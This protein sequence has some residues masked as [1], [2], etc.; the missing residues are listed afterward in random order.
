MN[1]FKHR[2]LNVVRALRESPHPACFTMKAWAHDCGTPGCAL[3]H[4]AYR[5]DLQSMFK[6]RATMCTTDGTYACIGFQSTAHPVETWAGHFGLSDAEVQE[7]FSLEGCG[8]AQT[9][10]EAALYI[11]K[12]VDTAKWHEPIMITIN[13]TVT[14]AEPT[15][16]AVDPAFARFMAALAAPA[17]RA[18]EE[19]A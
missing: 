1:I 16:P 11:E 9:A 3:G 12:F 10:L 6:L 2:L 13:L 14:A 8:N 15:V 4:Y 5:T 7:L 17:E 18:L 19:V